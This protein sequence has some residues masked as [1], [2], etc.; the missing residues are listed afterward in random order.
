[1]LK[2]FEYFILC[3][4]LIGCKTLPETNYQKILKRTD[5]RLTSEEVLKDSSIITL[6]LNTEFRS[7]LDASD[8]LVAYLDQQPNYFSYYKH[9]RFK[10][11][12]KKKY[13]LTIYS[14]CDCFGFRKFVFEPESKI[15]SSDGSVLSKTLIKK[16]CV[17]PDNNTEMPFH[18]IVEWEFITP[19]S[20]EYNIIIFANNDYRGKDINVNLL[21]K[22]LEILKTNVKGSFMISISEN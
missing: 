9:F 2:L 22:A 16:D 5:V 13:K 17:M 3:I 6:N 19:K 15:I 10:A 14:F 11:I 18:I 7:T 21:I 4:F 8:H 12:E 1:M 20:E